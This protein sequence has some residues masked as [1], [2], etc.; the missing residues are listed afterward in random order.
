MEIIHF[1]P[2]IIKSI[3]V[4]RANTGSPKDPSPFRKRPSFRIASATV[5]FRSCPPKVARVPL[6]IEDASPWLEAKEFLIV[7]KPRSANKK[8]AKE[9][10]LLAFLPENP[11]N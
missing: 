7:K 4:S 8:W 3:L 1:D 10:R 11:N 2:R 9:N 6:S 5:F